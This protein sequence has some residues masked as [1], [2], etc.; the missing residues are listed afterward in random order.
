MVI[1]EVNIPSRAKSLDQNVESPQLSHLDIVE[2]DLLAR[3]AVLGDQLDDLVDVGVVGFR[4]WILLQLGGLA[5]VLGKER[6][7][8]PF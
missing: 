6:L 1:L 8:L 3:R 7:W 2:I 5:V 4:I